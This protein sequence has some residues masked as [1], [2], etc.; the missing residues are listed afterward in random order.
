MQLN[1]LKDIILIVIL[2]VNTRVQLT[3]TTDCVCTQPSQV[4]ALWRQTGIKCDLLNTT[5]DNFLDKPYHFL[6]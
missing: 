2:V 6:G 4:L 1:S 3:D 5:D